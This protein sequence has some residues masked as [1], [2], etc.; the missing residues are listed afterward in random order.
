MEGL[1]EFFL[2]KLS[3]RLPQ[4]ASTTP[5]LTI[6]T[7]TISGLSLAFTFSLEV[8]LTTICY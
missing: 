5:V 4:K 3:V 6:G 8:A 2:R 7:D 1:R